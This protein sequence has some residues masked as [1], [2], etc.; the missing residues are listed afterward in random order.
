[1]DGGGAGYRSLLKP[2]DLPEALLS[3]ERRE[4]TASIRNAMPIKASNAVNG[5]PSSTTAMEDSTVQSGRFQRAG[6]TVGAPAP[7]SRGPPVPERRS[8]AISTAAPQTPAAQNQMLPRFLGMREGGGVHANTDCAFPSGNPSIPE[9]AA[10]MGGCK[11]SMGRAA[12][13][14]AIKMFAALPHE[15]QL[16]WL[17]GLEVSH[18]WQVQ[19][20]TGVMS[21]TG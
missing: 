3:I 4:P 8:P 20:Y 5:V 1:M 12:T 6:V 15:W 17:E 16:P 21:R 7:G 10:A 19:A 2:F 14:S 9:C 13:T 11:G 18:T